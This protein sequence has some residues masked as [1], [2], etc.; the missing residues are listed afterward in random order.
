MQAIEMICAFIAAAV[1]VGVVA[2]S[3][4]LARI[5]EGIARIASACEEDAGLDD[6]DEM[7]APKRRS[8]LQVGIRKHN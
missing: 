6:Q 3:W 2:T 5:N 4:L 1:F 7:P 8:S